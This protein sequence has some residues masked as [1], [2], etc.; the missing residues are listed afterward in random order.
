MFSYLLSLKFIEQGLGKG[1]CDG[2]ICTLPLPPPTSLVYLPTF[3]DANAIYEDYPNVSEDPPIIFGTRSQ[4]IL[5][6]STTSPLSK[7]WESSVEE[8]SF[9]RTFQSI[10]ALSTNY[11]F[12]YYILYFLGVCHIW[13]QELILSS[14]V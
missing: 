7:I 13:L 6:P 14:K 10:V 3:S 9:M 4:D 8:P 1:C 5:L 2:C 11:T 12:T